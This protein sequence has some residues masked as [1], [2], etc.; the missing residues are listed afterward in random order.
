MRQTNK[1]T[2]YLSSKVYPATWEDFL[3]CPTKQNAHKGT[4]VTSHE[5]CYAQDNSCSARQVA[6]FIQ[7][8]MGKRWSSCSFASWTVS[9]GSGTA[10][11][12]ARYQ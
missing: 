7:M 3:S 4:V 12:T 11:L 6:D 8:E 5:G 10:V 2:K 1:Q 9:L